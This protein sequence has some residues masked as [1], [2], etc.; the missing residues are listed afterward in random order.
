MTPMQ[1][2]LEIAK[3]QAED[4]G[5]YKKTYGQESNLGAHK[6]II[7][8]LS[9]ALLELAETSTKAKE[10]LFVSSDCVPIAEKYNVVDANALHAENARLRE[11]LD[12]LVGGDSFC[13]TPNTIKAAQEALAAAK[14]GA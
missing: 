10:T 14:G 5:Y 9:V 13:I 6:E 1:E 3:Q 7:Y 4:L 12:L 11:A 2:A 8:I